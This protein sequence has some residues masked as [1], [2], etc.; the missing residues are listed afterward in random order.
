MIPFLPVQDGILV[1]LTPE[2]LDLLSQ[3]PEFL[4]SLGDPVD[5]PAAARLQSPVYREDR[6]ASDEWWR[7][8]VDEFRES[9]AADR[10][11]FELILEA[12]SAGTVASVAEAEAFMRVLNESRLALAA[13]LGVE[14][15]GDMERLEEDDRGALDYLAGLQQLL[16]VALMGEELE[17]EVEP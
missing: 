9:R 14:D 15:E 6:D 2:D 5:D 13:R 8:M 12:A 17:F 10:S 16:V 4:N 7:L 11:A 1:T 3:L